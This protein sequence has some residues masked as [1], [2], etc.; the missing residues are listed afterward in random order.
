VTG[1]CNGWNDCLGSSLILLLSAHDKLCRPPAHNGIL[2]FDRNTDSM[3]ALAGLLLLLQCM[4][5][6][7]QE[8]LLLTTI[9]VNRAI[10][11]WCT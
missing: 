6:G 9:V 7:C 4:I 1:I 2:K 5:F 10:E 8:P 11:H 3:M